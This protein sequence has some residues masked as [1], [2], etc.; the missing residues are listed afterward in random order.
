MA[1]KKLKRSRS[2]SRSRSVSITPSTIPQ[3]GDQGPEGQPSLPHP[4]P[5]SHRAKKLKLLASHSV[6]SPF[7][8][9]PHPTPTEAGQIHTLLASTHPDIV[10]FYAPPPD[11]GVADEDGRGSG[12]GS[13]NAAQTC[14][15]VANVL[16]SLIGTILS[17]NTTAKN[18][19]AAKHALDAAF[20]LH[21]FRA[22]AEARRE[23]VAEA[24]K[25]GGLANKKAGIIQKILR[26]VYERHGAYSLQHLSRVTPTT[27]SFPSPSPSSQ[28]DPDAKGKTK[29]GGGA[30]DQDEAAA[31][32]T[33]EEAMHELVSYDGVGPKTASC[34]LLFCL[35]RASFPV[36]THVF[37]LSR[38]LGWVP[39]RAD[40]VTAQAHLDLAIP[41]GLK[42]GLHVLM[43]GHGRRCKGCKGTGGGKG[44]CVLK[45]WI[46]DQKSSKER[47]ATVVKAEEDT[48]AVAL[49]GSADA[50]VKSEVS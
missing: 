50:D 45:R 21:N 24:I 4:H 36:D 44:D 3:R 14:G 39:P 17:Q 30:Y 13:S 19:T 15:R 1:P 35:G 20:G 31:R 40:R 8:D 11:E 22:I 33:D 38:L 46:R 9:F 18:S 29:G 26:E 6:S 27:T 2:R 37:R 5:P 12:G 23:D 49:D 47:E 10:S 25:T 34:V 7:P 41:D 32:V 43:V 48:S 42:Y 28:T 16:D